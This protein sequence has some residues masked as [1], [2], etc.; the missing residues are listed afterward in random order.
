MFGKKTY[1]YIGNLRIPS[2]RI[3]SIYSSAGLKKFEKAFIARTLKKTNKK[4]NSRKLRLSENK[5]GLNL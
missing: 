3:M 4:N 2:P 1:F 5:Y